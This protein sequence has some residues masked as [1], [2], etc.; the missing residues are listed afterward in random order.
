M[1]LR[2]EFRTVHKVISL[3]VLVMAAGYFVNGNYFTHAST[4]VAVQRQAS[5]TGVLPSTA[6][7]SDFGL[8]PRTK[9]TGCVARGPL[10]DPD[11]TP[12]A[13]FPNA[14]T[15]QICV[16]GYS[17]TVRNVTSAEKDEVFRE[18]QEVRITGAYE[19]D[20]L[21]SLELGGSND[22]A[23]LWPEPALPTPGFHEK[24]LVENY[25]HKQVCA[26]AMSLYEAQKL[27]ATGWLGVYQKYLVH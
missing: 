8:K 10:P 12:G 19:V 4:T 22:I 27:I 9:T 25:L 20:H 21:I 14:S 7:S 26:G 3:A 1:S 6:T 17:A 11:C 16:S 18:Y 15:T 23:N 5:S 13:I 2:S 24:D